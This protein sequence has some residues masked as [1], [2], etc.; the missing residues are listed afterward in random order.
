M[1]V[2]WQMP[3]FYAIG[4]FRLKDYAR[5]SIPILPLTRGIFRTKVHMVFYSLGFLLISTLLTSF[6]YANF[7]YF[8][9]M[10]LLNMGWLILSIRGLTCKND[11]IWAR[12]MFRFSLAIISFLSLIIPFS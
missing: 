5:G 2:F 3:H 8:L 9:T 6:D 4:I 12:K 7:L 11:Q 10:S 1:L